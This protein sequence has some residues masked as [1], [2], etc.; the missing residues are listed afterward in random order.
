VLVGESLDANNGGHSLWLD[1]ATVQAVEPDAAPDT[2]LV[3]L[4]PGSDVDAYVRRVS[5]AQPDLL[6]VRRAS[7]DA[8]SITQTIEDVLLV[9]TAVMI[10]IAVAGIFNTLLLNSRERIRDTATLKAIGMSPRQ[11]MV[12][13]AASAAPLAI[14]AGALAIPAGIGLDRIFFNI[15]GSTAGGND[16]P[17]AVYQVFAAWELLAI[18][19]TG[20]AVAMAAALIPGRWAART[21]VVAALHAE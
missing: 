19:L 3:A 20:V 4:H 6:D 9:L 14:V 10:V 18:A 13:V 1:L 16:I 15:L 11:V 21:N 12:M 7:V 8:L 17:P 2:Y 5:A